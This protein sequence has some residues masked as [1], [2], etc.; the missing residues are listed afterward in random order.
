MISN[1]SNIIGLAHVLGDS[2]G[3]QYEFRCNASREYKRGFHYPPRM[4][5][6][7][8]GTKTCVLGQW[9]DDTEMA[10]CL[11][12]YLIESNEYNSNG[13]IPFYMDWANS[14]PYGMG[15]T[16][17]TLFHGITTV[18]GYKKRVD[19]LRKSNDST[20]GS[21]SNGSLMRAWPLAFFSNANEAVVEDC[22]LSNDNPINIECNVIY[23]YMIQSLI[24]KTFD[25]HH[26]IDMATIDVVKIAIADALE[27]REREFLEKQD[28]WVVHALYF[29]VFAAIS[30][31]S[32]LDIYDH[33]IQRRIDPDTTGAIA[34]AV[35]GA[36]YQ[37]EFLENV[38]IRELLQIIL[39][40]NPSDGS[41]KRPSIYHPKTYYTI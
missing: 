7:F 33:I 17:R 34:G 10:L 19:R 21:Q 41:V 37:N 32:I 23:I 30:D 14:N 27:N 26:L 16:T 25:K 5:T 28:G 2:L 15:V 9:T 35:L 11:V 24:D 4:I 40:A 3:A 31:M 18:N 36:K 29:A 38:E 6:R 8:Q 20:L 22:K 39:D 13:V 12:R 1:I